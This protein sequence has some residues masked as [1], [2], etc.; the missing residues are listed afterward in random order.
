MKCPW[1]RSSVLAF[2]RNYW[3]TSRMIVLRVASIA[4]FAPLRA[5]ALHLRSWIDKCRFEFCLIWCLRWTLYGLTRDHTKQKASLPLFGRTKNSCNGYAT[6]ST[7]QE[8]YAGTKS[9]FCEEL[10]WTKLYGLYPSRSGSLSTCFEGTASGAESGCNR[11]L[12]RR[13]PELACAGPLKRLVQKECTWDPKARQ[14]LAA[15]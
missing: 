2:K 15:K 10:I 5:Y 14:S 1:C 9:I 11:I 12:P 3:R 13:I 8:I 6:P 7:P 4:R